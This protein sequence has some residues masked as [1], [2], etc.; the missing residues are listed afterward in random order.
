MVSQKLVK[1]TKKDKPPKNEEDPRIVPNY[2][3]LLTDKDRVR[4]RESKIEWVPR[5]G[6][7]LLVAGSSG[8]G[9]TNAVFKLIM[10][11]DMIQYDKLFVFAKLVHEEEKYKLLKN[12]MEERRKLLS[13]KLDVEVPLKKLYEYSDNLDDLPLPKDLVGNIADNTGKR[14]QYCVII[15]DFQGSDKNNLNKLKE[16]A[17]YGRKLGVTTIYI[18]QDYF[19]TSQV[20][21]DNA[22]HIMLFNPPNKVRMTEL[23]KAYADVIEFSEFK[24]M[25]KSACSKPYQFLMINT[26]CPY[27]KI[28]KKYSQGFGNFA[29]I[30]T[31]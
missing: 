9:K 5:V 6:S 1:Q 24:Q 8:S 10:D 29:V 26:Q 25:F 2:D 18:Y 27:H 13:K 20:M 16:Y 21:R 19:Q 4:W 17:I 3:E 7:R 28:N 22:T 23:A 11:P 30:D 14:L 31:T 12:E 15:D